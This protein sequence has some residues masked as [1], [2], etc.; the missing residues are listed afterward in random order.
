MS[1]AILIKAGTFALLAASSCPVIV[2]KG[3]A[4]YYLLYL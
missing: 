2:L 4:L 3:A 1:S